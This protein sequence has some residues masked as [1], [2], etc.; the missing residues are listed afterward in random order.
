MARTPASTSSQ[1]P[2]QPSPSRQPERF[3][4]TPKRRLL[5]DRAARWIVSA[6]GVAIIASIL[7]ILFFILVEVRPLL[8]GARVAPSRTVQLAASTLVAT[9]ASS[10][11]AK[12]QVTALLADEQR[13]Y[14]AALDLAGR[15]QVADLASGK[16]VHEVDL[17]S[18]LTG[19]A[20]GP[21]TTG[22]ASA[23]AAP[24]RAGSPRPTLT[25]LAVPAERSAF[26]AATSDGRVLLKRFDFTF[27]NRG[28]T[29]SFASDDTPVLALSLDPAGR[30]LSVFAAQ[31]DGE[32]GALAAAALAGGQVAIVHRAVAKNE[33]TGE[34]TEMLDRA[35]V[36][37][38][39]HA[40]A[41]AI[42]PAQK[43][44]FVGTAEGEI[45]WW[46]LEGGKPGP[47]RTAS[48]G[49]P[50]T[51]L[52]LL[53]GGRS[54]AVGQEDGA[55]SVWFGVH[56]PDD[57]LRLTRVH[58]FPRHPGAV[59]LLALSRRDRGFLAWG[60][61]TL[62]LYFATNE[63]TLW[64][65]RSPVQAP[66]ALAFAPKGDGA[67]LAGGGRVAEIRIDNPHPEVTLGSLF[68]KSW[69]EG[70]ER[71]AY[72]WQSSGGTDDF[73][74]KMSL[75]PLLVGT[76]KGTFYSLLLAIPLGVFGAMY[77]SM[78]MHPRYKRTL[79]P[80]IEIMASLPSVVLGFLAG[81]W[82]APRVE[83]FLPGL[84]LMAVV[85][86]LLILAAGA[87][88]QRL[89]RGFRGRFPA[90]SE[91]ILF[92][93]VLAG[94]IALCVR[95][96]AP[97]ER[98]AFHGDFKEWILRWTGL[99]YDQ[100]NAVVVGL[101]MGFSVIP[102]LFAIA[103]DAFS[104]VPANLVAGSLAMGAD[105][106]QTVTRVVLPTASPGIFSA[107]MIGFGRA[108]GETMIVL[109]AT[110]NTP[111][112]DWNPF[113]G[114][115]TLS[116]NIAVEIPEAPHGGTLYRTLFLAALLLFAMTFLVNTA[117]ELVRQRLRE[118]YSQL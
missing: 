90:G 5:A 14:L 103:E 105:R 104:N 77:T 49:S 10:L 100:R 53:L 60:G 106:W 65:G 88:W 25:S 72:V 12:A 21:G 94:G 57:S 26:T 62:G 69:F 47:R 102:I 27:V 17:L 84:L 52:S 98:L 8:R 41:M 71:P 75:V 116:A 43:S 107:I 15:L 61:G 108:V 89:P 18:G 87:G 117:A 74:P 66:T 112:M 11:P 28:D 93:G 37:L 42:D 6:G 40:T 35:E 70:Y 44:L 109:M 81:L 114:F 45:H 34:T 20:P 64:R 29:R 110:G 39:G 82:L 58:D 92:V 13:R 19:P 99:G 46:Q 32:G 51:A 79:K 68:G 118:R 56:Q 115:R 50:I 73:E 63:R 23:A 55:L 113:N 78:F 83:K 96:A 3:L 38:P 91:A 85:L 48:A 4:V 9:P 111:I 80:M 16:T 31:I 33:M 54:L 7:G 101:A 97:F 1:R 59:R 36:E 30:P 67:Y 76:L 22:P 86:P 24:P 95:L 2:P